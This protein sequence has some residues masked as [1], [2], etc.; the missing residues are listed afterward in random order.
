MI[1]KKTVV[2]SVFFS[3]KKKTK[4]LHDNI[5]TKLIS[6]QLEAKLGYKSNH[7]MVNVSTY[8]LSKRTVCTQHSKWS[9][10]L[11][12]PPCLS[13]MAGRQSVYCW[14]RKNGHGWSCFHIQAHNASLPKKQILRIDPRTSSLPFS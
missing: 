4:T 2:F 5:K 12:P 14:P 10:R 13:G 8:N 1:R 6:Y 3:N 9:Y 7:A 11:V